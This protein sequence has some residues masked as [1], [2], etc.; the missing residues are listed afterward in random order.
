MMI[1]INFTV[2]DTVNDFQ[3]NW[4]EQFKQLPKTARRNTVLL[5]RL[6][7]IYKQTSKHWQTDDRN[8]DL[9][10]GDVQREKSKCTSQQAVVNIPS[11][12]IAFIGCSQLHIKL[13]IIYLKFNVTCLKIELYLD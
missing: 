12:G 7:N 6:A 5:F 8:S 4:K 11:F 10:L 2:T 1:I 3:Y 13:D 9:V